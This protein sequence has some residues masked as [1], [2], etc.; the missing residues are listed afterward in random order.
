MYACAGVQKQF[1]RYYTLI[2]D[3]KYY[4]VKYWMKIMLLVIKD[5][6]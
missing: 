4:F 2:L 1:N 6:L 5:I 3:V